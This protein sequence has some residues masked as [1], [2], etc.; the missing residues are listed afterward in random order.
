[1]S[2]CGD[3]PNLLEIGWTYPIKGIYVPE[4]YKLTVFENSKYS[5]KR[6]SVTQSNFNLSGNDYVLINKAFKV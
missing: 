1:M 3:I 5:G 6:Y 2:F 4:G